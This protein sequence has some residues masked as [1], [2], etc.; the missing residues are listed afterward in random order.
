MVMTHKIQGEIDT[1]LG[2]AEAGQ[3]W[4][5]RTCCVAVQAQDVAARD[6][7]CGGGRQVKELRLLLVVHVPSTLV[8]E[9][10]QIADR[11][12]G[13]GATS[14]YAMCTSSVTL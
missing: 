2:P 3:G 12:H 6:G 14:S 11:G 13:T 8:R 1:A 7:R 4:L 9:T 5:H 10:Q